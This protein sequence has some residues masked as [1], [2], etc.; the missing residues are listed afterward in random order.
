MTPEQKE[1]FDHI[2][3][4][5]HRVGM[6]IAAIP[7]AR[8][9]AV[10]IELARRSIVETAAEQGVCDSKIVEICAD[11]IEVVVREIMMSGKPN[12]GHA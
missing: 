6:K 8:E 10:A 7:D 2:M 3:G 11:G 1:A 4:F 9:R 5:V 12:G